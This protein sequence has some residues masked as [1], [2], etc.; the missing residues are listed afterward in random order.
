LIPTLKSNYRAEYGVHLFLNCC[1]SY[2][3][4]IDKEETTEGKEVTFSFQQ[5]FG[6]W[7]SSDGT[8]EFPRFDYDFPSIL[9]QH[10]VYNCG[11]AGIANAFAFVKHLKDVK[12]ST[13]KMISD[14]D[15]HFYL[16]KTAYSLQPFWKNVVDYANTHGGFTLTTRSLLSRMREEYYFVLKDLSLLYRADMQ[17]KK[18]D[19]IK[20]EHEKI[21]NV[22]INQK[23]EFKDGIKMTNKEEKGQYIVDFIYRM[24]ECNESLLQL[25]CKKCR[26]SFDRTIF[27][28]VPKMD[29]LRFS[30][31]WET[32]N[33]I[34]QRKEIKDLVE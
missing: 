20:E 5:P 11:F 13:T 16:D 22:T 2:L 9:C 30:L 21:E 24:D 1:A 8:K 33:S 7:N 6:L 26:T 32:P 34:K 28:S 23:K 19:A 27:Y 15:G 18:D 14:K 10:D 3:Y 12:F 4:S 29:T 17:A 25:D 31:L